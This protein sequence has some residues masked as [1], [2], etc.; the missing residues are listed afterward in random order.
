MTALPAVGIRK[1]A[2]RLVYGLLILAAFHFALILA[3]SAVYDRYGLSPSTYKYIFPMLIVNDALP[4]VLWFLFFSEEVMAL[5]S[6]KSPPVKA[7]DS[8]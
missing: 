1:K 3:V 6:R 5:F 8:N 4:L 7:T 2:F